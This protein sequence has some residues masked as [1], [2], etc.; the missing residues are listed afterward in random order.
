MEYY[1]SYYESIQ[2][3]KK[4]IKMPHV[5]Y[6]KCSSRLKDL[7]SIMYHCE[8]R[9]NETPPSICIGD[10]ILYQISAIIY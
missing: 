2:G 6:C 8:N 4:Y 1:E 10:L 7:Y 9:I 3:N 5:K